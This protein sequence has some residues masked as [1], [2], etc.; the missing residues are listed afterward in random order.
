MT[1]DDWTDEDEE[2]IE[3]V[4]KVTR[5]TP[6]ERR[7]EINELQRRVAEETAKAAAEAAEKAKAA[8]KAETEPEPP[9]DAAKAAQEPAA[10]SAPELTP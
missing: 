6:W 4:R 2:T 3:R 10:F 1:A 8:A 5:R 9:V 7:A